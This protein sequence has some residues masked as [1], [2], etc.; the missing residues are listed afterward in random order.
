M[1]GQESGGCPPFFS[2]I[3]T[4]LRNQQH[5]KQS[6]CSDR[7][8]Y[9]CGVPLQT[10]QWYFPLSE[11]FNRLQGHTQ[12]YWKIQLTQCICNKRTYKQCHWSSQKT[13]Q[14]LRSP[15]QMYDN[16][17]YCTAYLKHKQINNNMQQH[18][19]ERIYIPQ[20]WYCNFCLTVICYCC[21]MW[22]PNRNIYFGI[23][24][25]SREA[26][27]WSTLNWWTYGMWGLWS[28]V[29]AQPNSPEGWHL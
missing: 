13:W 20:I 8:S 5:I 23:T 10:K 15:L 29:V 17:D 24:E 27:G 28:A 26:W 16:C 1:M 3:S 2:S 18:L 6:N 21:S 19:L 12:Y 14:Y 25:C 4:L 9:S 22:V 7:S 11:I